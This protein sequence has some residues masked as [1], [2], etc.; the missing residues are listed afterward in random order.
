M[1]MCLIHKPSR[2][3]L[4]EPSKLAV[5]WVWTFGSIPAGKVAVELIRKSMS[6]IAC[7]Q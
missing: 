2:E 1:M 6:V 4:H 3:I 7:F 5:P